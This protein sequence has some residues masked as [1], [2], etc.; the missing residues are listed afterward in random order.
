[1]PARLVAGFHSRPQTSERAMGP[2]CGRTA[3][4]APQASPRSAFANASV[5]GPPL[6]NPH[7]ATS[8]FGYLLPSF[9]RSN[10]RSHFG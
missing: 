9:F 7:R 4:I 10:A 3:R 1:M 2:D 8:S 6:L 5:A